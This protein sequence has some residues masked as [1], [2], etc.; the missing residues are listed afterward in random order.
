M[1]NERTNAINVFSG[2]TVPY[3]GMWNTIEAKICALRK[4]RSYTLLSMRV[5]LTAEESGSG[6]TVIDHPALD[7]AMWIETVPVSYLDELLRQLRDERAV[8]IG[9]RLLTL[10]TFENSL[11]RCEKF[12]G[13]YRGYLGLEYPYVLLQADGKSFHEV[14][15]WSALDKQLHRHGYGGLPETAQEN[16]S[17]PVGSA[18]ST[19]IVI[20]A[21][22]YLRF[23]S[24]EAADNSL[25]ISV[26]SH[27]SIPLEHI[28]ISYEVKYE[29]E[30][31]VKTLNETAN[32]DARHVVERSGRI[33]ILRKEV[34]IGGRIVEARAWLYDKWM[35]EPI[36]SAWVRQVAAPRESIAWRILGPLLEERHHSEVINGHSKLREYLC[37][38]YIDPALGRQFELAVA[39]LLSSMG[40]SVFFVGQPLP[41]RGVDIV[42]ICPDSGRS[43][44]VSAHISNDIH[45]KL[46]TLL[47]EFIRLRDS[48]QG[49]QLTPVL[50]SPVKIEDI[51]AS[52]RIDAKAHGV[53]L[54]LGKQIEELFRIAGTMMPGEARQRT[55]QFIDGILGEQSEW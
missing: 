54:M 33:Q 31:K 5:F 6:R 30:S 4:D 17:F 48:L 3:R 45:E 49:I 2:V 14:A 42:A 35:T 32:L 43:L 37:I 25:K 26:E 52:D 46:R 51:L 19:Q 13:R 47:P 36:D 7:V 53:V 39:H 24:V 1:P 11:W 38:D 23:K 34:D 40:F 21:P 28:T 20:A 41:K 55:L 15:D 44:I 50:F 10:E 22:L 12:S 16:L 29:E 27:S 8:T 18:Y 9:R